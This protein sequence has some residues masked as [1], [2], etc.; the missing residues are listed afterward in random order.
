MIPVDGMPHVDIATGYRL[1]EHALS[2]V[3]VDRTKQS[4]QRS[5]SDAGTLEACSGALH[6]SG[7]AGAETE[8]DSEQ[9]LTGAVQVNRY[10]DSV[11]NATVEVSKAFTGGSDSGQEHD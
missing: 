10:P 2:L 9:V 11:V 7:V 5:D 3:S 4:C 1:D 8:V 6:E